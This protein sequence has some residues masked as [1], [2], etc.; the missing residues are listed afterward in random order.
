MASIESQKLYK[1]CLTGQPDVGKTSI[2]NAI[3]GRPFSKS[4]KAET[5]MENVTIAVENPREPSQK[6]HVKVSCNSE[7]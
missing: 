1:V 2:F 7:L 6:L 4:P 5:D 3:R